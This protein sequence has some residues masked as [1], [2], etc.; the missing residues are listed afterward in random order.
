MNVLPF[1]F[2]IEKENLKEEGIYYPFEFW[3]MAIGG[4]DH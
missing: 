2:L 1:L 3:T 4:C